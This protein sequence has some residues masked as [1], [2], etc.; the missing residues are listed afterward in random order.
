MLKRKRG[1]SSG[2]PDETK[3]DEGEDG[4]RKTEVVGMEV[5]HLNPFVV[6]TQYK[7]M[8]IL[9]V[10]LQVKHSPLDGDGRPPSDVRFRRARK[11]TGS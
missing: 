8:N 3:A 7:G 1:A 2:L 4:V 6:M 9:D 10:L 11:R 5:F